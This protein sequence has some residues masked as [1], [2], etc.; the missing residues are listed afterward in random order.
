MK[1]FVISLCCLLLSGCDTLF[2]KQSNTPTLLP[3]A[4]LLVRC[5]SIPMIK[6]NANMGNLMTYTVDLMKLYNECAV[7]HDELV[8]VITEGKKKD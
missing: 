3:P 2:K 6:E 5:E 4:N 7:K 8:R 1:I